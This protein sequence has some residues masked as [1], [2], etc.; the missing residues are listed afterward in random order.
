MAHEDNS[1]IRVAP[2]MTWINLPGSNLLELLRFI[3]SS[4]TRILLNLITERCLCQDDR[5]KP[6]RSISSYISKNASSESLSPVIL[7]I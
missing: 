4:R 6:L 1:Y 7:V 2:A 3:A 5:D